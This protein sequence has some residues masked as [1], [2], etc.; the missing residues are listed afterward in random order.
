MVTL[1]QTTLEN[2]ALIQEDMSGHSGEPIWVENIELLKVRLTNRG[3]CCWDRLK[4]FH[5]LVDNREN[6]TN[7][8]DLCFRHL[9]A[10][11]RGNTK[12]INCTEPILG[13][14]VFVKLNGAILLT[15]CE[16]EV[17]AAAQVHN[18]TELPT[19]KAEFTRNI[20]KGRP[21]AQSSTCGGAS[22]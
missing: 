14:F 8:N 20:A 21:T 12:D 3:G 4:N 9:G 2:P 13:R 11:G 15:L 6:N 17:F 16:V 19:I 5:I 7:T 22:S 18:A 1:I 10:V